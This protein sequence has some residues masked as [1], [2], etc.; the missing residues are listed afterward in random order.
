MEETI[1][2]YGA[3]V[4]ATPVG[5]GSLRPGRH[6]VYGSGTPITNLFM[7]MLDRA[8]VRPEG[9]GDSTEIVQHLTDLA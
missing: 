9:I 1:E 5:D 2:Q 6:I 3:A 7:T 4:D 8:G